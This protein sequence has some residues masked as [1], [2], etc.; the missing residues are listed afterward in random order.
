MRHT[1]QIWSAKFLCGEIF[2]GRARV[3]KSARR[4]PLRPLEESGDTIRFLLIQF[5]QIRIDSTI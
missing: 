1:P 2:R 4:R 3:L 5:D